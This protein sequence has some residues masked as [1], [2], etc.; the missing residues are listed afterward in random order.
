MCS[1]T[2]SP[3]SEPAPKISSSH[4]W[5]TSK[6][7]PAH[8]ADGV[9]IPPRTPPA[10]EALLVLNDWSLETQLQLVLPAAV[11]IEPATLMLELGKY[12]EDW[13]AIKGLFRTDHIEEDRRAGRAER[14][15][16]E[17]RAAVLLR[18][19]LVPATYFVARRDSGA[20][21]CI[22]VWTRSDGAAM[23]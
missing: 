18:R 19:G 22:G 16:S 10:V 12:D 5:P 21:G 14:S 3:H 7:S 11:S 2:S 13:L 23:I 6:R 9:F 4:S 17:T 8:H 15:V 1:G 20:V